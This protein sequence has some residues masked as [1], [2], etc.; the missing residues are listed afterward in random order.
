[1]VID[2]IEDNENWA[3][4]QILL[5]HKNMINNEI[6]ILLKEKRKYNFSRIVSA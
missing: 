2:D 1:M 6:N 5:Q 4:K 3:I